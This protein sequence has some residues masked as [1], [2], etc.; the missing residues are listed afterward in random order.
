[1]T[2]F[3]GKRLLFELCQKGEVPSLGLVVNAEAATGGA[4]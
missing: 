2:S 4:L 3:F 1:M